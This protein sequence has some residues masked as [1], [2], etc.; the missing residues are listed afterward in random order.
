MPRALSEAWLYLQRAQNNPRCEAQVCLLMSEILWDA[1]LPM[2][3]ILF[4]KK[5][6]FQSRKWKADR[7]Y[8]QWSSKYY[9][10]AE[11]SL[12]CNNDG[13]W[14]WAGAL[15]PIGHLSSTTAWSALPLCNVRVWSISGIIDW[16]RT[17]AEHNDGGKAERDPSASW[18]EIMYSRSAILPQTQHY[19]SLSYGVAP[20]RHT[21]T[22]GES[23][24]LGSTAA[25]SSWR[26]GLACRSPHELSS[27]PDGKRKNIL[28]VW[29]TLREISGQQAGASIDANPCA[30]GLS[31][32]ATGLEQVRTLEYFGKRRKK[33]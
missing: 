19:G 30:A 32:E 24:F 2:C 3:W 29:A 18:G 16:S 33:S 22:F 8:V 23:C 27:L 11:C 12:V 5:E 1:L 21:L 31:L 26:N 6:S 17:T 9:N 13:E 4:S 7:L 14:W 15:S 20:F 28:S 10:W 25:S